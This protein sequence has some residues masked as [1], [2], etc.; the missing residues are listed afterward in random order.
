MNRNFCKL[1]SILLLI[2]GLFSC[3]NDLKEVQLLTQ[4]PKLL[5]TETAKGVDM[6]YSD[7][8][9]ATARLTAPLLLHY[10]IGVKE[11]YEELPKGIYVEFYDAS[12]KV[13]S[14]LKANYAIR[15][16]QTKKMEAKYK[17]EVISE[18]G[19][20]LN[21]E[22]LI[23]DEEKRKIIS[24]EFVKIT[25]QKEIITGEGLIAEQDFSEWEILKV[26]GVI[27][28]DEKEITK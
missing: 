26:K 14:I 9:K 20:K 24:D 13:K 18:N 16:E 22:H 10:T 27:K 25:T 4:K 23:W 15:N 12:N 2:S 1:F 17:V 7:S 11:P 3:E 21:T 28:V 19:D 6:I 8:G 5:P